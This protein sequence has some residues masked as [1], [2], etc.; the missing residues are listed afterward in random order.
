M[1]AGIPVIATNTG[2]TP[3]LLK[4]GAGILIPQ[5]DANA[6]A[7]ALTKLDSDRQFSW[8]LGEAGNRRVRNE[9]TIGS[10]ISALLN[11]LSSRGTRGDST[12]MECQRANEAS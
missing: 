12:T 10:T 9:F 11:E 2:G 8:R 4:D 1:A 7:K 3:E 5:Q 6:I